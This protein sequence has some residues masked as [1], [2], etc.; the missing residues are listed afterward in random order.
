MYR[1][2]RIFLPAWLADTVMVGFLVALV[3][4]VFVFWDGTPK[5]FHYIEI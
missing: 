1:L 2:L 4:L 5:G 3:L